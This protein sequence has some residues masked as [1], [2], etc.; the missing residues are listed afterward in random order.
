MDGP[1][2]L[3]E[4][5][6]LYPGTWHACAGEKEAHAS[7]DDINIDS[8]L[9]GHQVVSPKSPAPAWG[10]PLTVPL[11]LAQTSQF[12]WYPRAELPDSGAYDDSVAGW[13]SGLFVG[14]GDAARACNPR[15]ALGTLVVGSQHGHSRSSKLPH[16]KLHLAL[17]CRRRLNQG[18][19]VVILLVAALLERTCR[20]HHMGFLVSRHA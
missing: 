5:C 11:H 15:H 18:T 8:L 12:T 6:G 4:D 17:E 9:S 19:R 16:A 2:C 14:D 3:S 20:R 7:C 13:I 1:S 10:M